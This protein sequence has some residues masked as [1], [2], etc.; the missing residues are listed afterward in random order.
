[1]KH[2]IIVPMFNFVRNTFYYQTEIFKVL[3]FMTKDINTALS[4]Q[5][6]PIGK[7]CGYSCGVSGSRCRDPLN[8]VV[9]TH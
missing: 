2:V 4:S 5:Q 9:Q 7:V 6:W 3:H 8:D 1:M